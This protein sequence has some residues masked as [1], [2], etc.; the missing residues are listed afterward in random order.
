MEKTKQKYRHELKY[1]ITQ[2]ELALIKSRLEHLIPLDS[3]VKGIQY[4]ESV[5]R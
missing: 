5:L 1:V 4:P 3:H 2:T